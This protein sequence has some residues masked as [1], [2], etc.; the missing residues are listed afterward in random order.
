MFQQISKTPQTAAFMS[1]A[2]D[3]PTEPRQQMKQ[4]VLLDLVNIPA[5]WVPSYTPISAESSEMITALLI[6]HL[7]LTKGRKINILGYMAEVS[8]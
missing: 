6:I 4:Y 1:I 3:G 7:L 2:S 8:I 5:F